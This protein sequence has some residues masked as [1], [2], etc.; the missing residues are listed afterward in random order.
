[1]SSQRFTVTMAAA[2]RGGVLIPVPSDPDNVWGTKPRHHIRGTVN[3]MALRQQVAGIQQAGTASP[4]PTV[5]EHAN[6]AAAVAVT[7]VRRR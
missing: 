2:G 3:G 6:R 4:H 5:S 7:A 1:V